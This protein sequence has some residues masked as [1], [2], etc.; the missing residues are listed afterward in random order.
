MATPSTEYDNLAD[1]QHKLEFSPD[2][3]VWTEVPVLQ[4]ADY[5]EETPVTDDITPT[6]AHR[7]IN[8]KV[9][10][11]E[12]GT[13]TGQFVYK[14]GGAAETALKTAYDDGKT[15]FWRMTFEDAPS[16]NIKFEGF[17]A[18]YSITAEKKKKIRVDFEIS[19]TSDLTT[20]VITP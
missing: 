10:F 5:P 13:I 7:T 4:E 11:I 17:L 16:L 14:E 8:A 15:L 9:D 20:P 1:S 3:T 18:K 2:G 6:D 19:I 12:D